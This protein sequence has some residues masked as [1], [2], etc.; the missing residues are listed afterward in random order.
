M[1]RSERRRRAKKIG[2]RRLEEAI[3]VDFWGLW[4]FTDRTAGY[5]RKKNPFTFPKV[6]KRGWHKKKKERQVR[7]KDERRNSL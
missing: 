4:H 3:A 6:P 1:D 7:I 2:E 5:F